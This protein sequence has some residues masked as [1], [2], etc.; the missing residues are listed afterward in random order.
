MR[1]KVSARSA[2]RVSDSPRPTRQT[3]KPPSAAHP[4]S[5][6][7]P[8][9]TVESPL[10]IAI[11]MRPGHSNSSD[12]SAKS[13]TAAPAKATRVSQRMTPLCP[14]CWYSCKEIT[15]PTAN[16]G[17]NHKASAVIPRK[18]TGSTCAASIE[19]NAGASNVN[20]MNPI[21]PMKIHT[22]MKR[23]NTNTRRSK[24]DGAR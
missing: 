14:S 23:H 20:G 22:S 18:I 16:I 4:I 17:A 5:R 24:G 15:Q 1:A 2:A 13:A 9:H 12:P 6:N 10:A 11:T 7:Q 8:Y 19:P 3:A 21:T